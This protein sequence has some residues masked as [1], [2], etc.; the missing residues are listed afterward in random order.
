MLKPPDLII[1]WF[2]LIY[3]GVLIAMNISDNAKLHKVIVKTKE[4]ITKAI[5]ICR[6]YENT[7][8]SNICKGIFCFDKATKKNISEYFLFNASLSNV[9]S[10]IQSQ[11]SVLSSIIIDADKINNIEHII[12]CS[13]LMSKYEDFSYALAHF[14]SKFD[15][16]LQDILLSDIYSSYNELKKRLNLYLDYLDSF[17]L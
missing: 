12:V 1:R 7:F 3:E 10:A 6:A 2:W 16:K 4:E 9:L 8:P 14:A 13:E 5:D 17:D 11:Y 15:S